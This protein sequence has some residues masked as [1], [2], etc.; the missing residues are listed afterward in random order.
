MRFDHNDIFRGNIYKDRIKQIV[1]DI[2]LK[3]D[4]T[5]FKQE[6]LERISS[7]LYNDL[8]KIF[9]FVKDDNLNEFEMEKV[10]LD[11]KYEENKSFNEHQFIIKIEKANLFISLIEL[12]LEYLRNEELKRLFLAWL[13]Y[14]ET[15]K[16]KECLQKLQAYTR[17]QINSNALPTSLVELLEEREK[18]IKEII[19]LRKKII[20]LEQEIVFHEESI[21]HSREEMINYIIQHADDI[22]YIDSHGVERKFFEGNTREEREDFIRNYMLTREAGIRNRL[23]LGIERE[24]KIENIASLSPPP[25]GQRKSYQPFMRQLKSAD[26]V[27]RV[28]N[29]FDSRV[30]QLRNDELQAYKDVMIRNNIQNVTEDASLEEIA[31]ILS[32]FERNE[33]MEY[34]NSIQD[35][36]VADAHEN[37]REKQVDIA[38]TREDVEKKEAMVEQIDEKVRKDK[39]KVKEDKDEAKNRK[40]GIDKVKENIGSDLTEID[41]QFNLVKP[42]R[43]TDKTLNQ[44]N[45]HNNTFALNDLT[46]SL[47]SETELPESDDKKQENDTDSTFDLDKMTGSLFAD[48]E[49]SETPGSEKQED[50]ANDTFDLDELT[51][52]LFSEAESSGTSNG[53]S[54]LDVTVEDL[55]ASN[56]VK[57]S[58]SKPD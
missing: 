33:N 58:I 24:R 29:N 36:V 55:N 28:E 43:N 10:R 21:M 32:R 14:L 38:D 20:R 52:L 22:T 39:S 54:T 53:I 7:I 50:A 18:L 34:A 44:E 4:D 2:M 47:L 11:K 30:E 51:A 35:E 49:L 46:E 9:I 6:E 5:L 17:A 25:N 57:R 27:S 31:E 37:I 40:G 48:D 19:F 1:K 13:D 16:A 41:F 8:E 45:K 12:N 15:E 56:Q 26:A 42:Q 23:D 3:L